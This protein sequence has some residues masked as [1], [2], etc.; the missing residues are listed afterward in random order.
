MLTEFIVDVGLPTPVAIAF[1]VIYAVTAVTVI[2]LAVGFLV[3]WMMELA[4]RVGCRRAA[5]PTPP[6]P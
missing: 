5:S 3:Y 1:A 4:N 6:H 2:S